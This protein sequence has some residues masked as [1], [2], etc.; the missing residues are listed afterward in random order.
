M[1][2]FTGNPLNRASEKRSDAA[3]IEAK[4]RDPGTLILPMWRLMPF[5]LGD[6]KSTAPEL[7]LFRPG[8]CESLAAPDAACVFLGLEG[9]QALFALDVS[10]A[11]IRRRA[12][13]WPASAISATRA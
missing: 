3:W 5:L 4:R 12:G 11:P 13:R 10:A 9:D 6:E 7:G 2:P 1:I 8:L